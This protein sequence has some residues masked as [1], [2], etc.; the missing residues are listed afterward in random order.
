MTMMEKIHKENPLLTRWPI[1]CINSRKV[2]AEEPSA[3]MRPG[4]LNL[5]EGEERAKH[6]LDTTSQWRNGKSDIRAVIL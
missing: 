1:S 2:G 5:L 3:R 6:Q 4:I